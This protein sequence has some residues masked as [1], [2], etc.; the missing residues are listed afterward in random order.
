MFHLTKKKKRG[1]SLNYPY[2][3]VAL[4]CS[5]P[6]KVERLRTSLRVPVQLTV[7]HNQHMELLLLFGVCY[8]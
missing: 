8:N 1:R 6:L 5:I 2:I 3:G 4:L 7:I